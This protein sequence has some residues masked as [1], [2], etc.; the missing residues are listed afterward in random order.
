MMRDDQKRLEVDMYQPVKV[1][2]TDQGYTVYGEVKHCDVVALKGDELLIVELKQ[3]LNM[4]LLLQAAKRLRLTSQVYVAILKPKLSYRSSKWR[5]ICHL[6]RRL[7]LGM[8][9]IDFDKTDV[10]TEILFHPKP[11]DRDKSQ[12]R[13]KKKRDGMLAE[14]KGRTG[15]FNV[16]GSRQTKIMSA[17]KESCIQI[18]CILLRKGPLTAKVLRDMGTGDKTSAILINNYY[19]W[20]DR[21]QRGVYML[22]ETGKKELQAFSEHISQ[23]EEE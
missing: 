18:A 15:D 8:I 10:K 3:S 13:S 22:N 9:I 7:E 6:L 1:L 17:Y 16:G 12:Q 23:F 4:D 5:D 21:I 20:F 19:G 2:L 14:I 11:F